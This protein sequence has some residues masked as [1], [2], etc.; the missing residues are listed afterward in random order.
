MMQANSSRL[1]DDLRAF[2]STFRAWLKHNLPAEW[3]D[4][5]RGTPE[6]VLVPVRREWGARLHQGGWAGVTWP[7]EVGGQGLELR[8]QLVLVEEQVNVGAP[9]PLNSNGIQILGPLLLRYGS[10]GQRR[11]FLRPMLAHDEIWCQGFSEPNAGSDLASL[12]TRAIADGASWRITGQKLWTTYAQEADY[13]YLLA[14]TDSLPGSKYSGIS[15]FTVDMHQQG[16]SLRPVRNISG[17]EEFNEVFFDEAVAT[18]DALIGELGQGWEIANYALAYERGLSF[19]ARALKLTREFKLLAELQTGRDGRHGASADC[20]VATR[21]MRAMVLEL[22]ERSAAGRDLGSLASI[23]K[24][25]WSESHQALLR[26]AVETLGREATRHS[27]VEWLNS[28]LSS[29]AET[30]YGGTSEIQRSLIAK[31]LGL[32]SAKP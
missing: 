24:L 1:R 15:M 22:L 18:E 27:N 28:L 14:R 13:C 30:I 32:P 2:Q 16:V 23:A 5:S 31:A 12:R 19:A 20:Y 17:S 6:E 10:K 11:R 4:L 21:A 9:E 8:H 25:Y 29:R 7:A 3:R 26:L